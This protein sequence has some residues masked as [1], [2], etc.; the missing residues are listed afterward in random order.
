MNK[1]LFYTIFIFCT[2]FTFSNVN[3]QETGA[4]PTLF[5]TEPLEIPSEDNLDLIAPIVANEQI[6]I[7]S[8]IKLSPAVIN[9]ERGSSYLLKIENNTNVTKEFTIVKSAFEITS[10]RKLKKID[11]VLEEKLVNELE[12]SIIIEDE[13]LVIEPYQFKNVSIE[14]KQ[15]ILNYLNGVIVKQ[16]DLLENSDEN[17]SK[18]DFSG[19]LASVIIDPTLTREQLDQLKNTITI[20]P[21]KSFFG[22][23]LN[24]KFKI[25]TNISNNSAKLLK[26]SGDITLYDGETRID[27]KSLTQNYPSYFYP[28]DEVSIEF[29]FNKDERSVFNQIGERSAVKTLKING[30]V[31]QISDE[32]YVLPYKILVLLILLLSTLMI[33]SFLG[34]RYYKSPKKSK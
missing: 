2:V 33:T 26:I 28:N 34:Y 9:L 24:S 5:N 20:E 7:E 27:S 13:L 12:E 10:D 11:D 23:A 25:K 8:S 18:L 4:V 21:E 1:F 29:D 22:I 6:N 17:Q 30:E 16:R 31:V 19:Q 15:P 32:I 14:Y 3:A